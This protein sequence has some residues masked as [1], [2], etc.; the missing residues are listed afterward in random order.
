MDKLVYPGVQVWFSIWKSNNM[1]L[2]INRI[3]RKLTW[4][5]QYTVYRKNIWKSQ[6]SF[7]IKTLSRIEIENNSFNPIIGTCKV[8]TA[9]INFIIKGERQY[10]F[11]LSVGTKLF[12]PFSISI[13]CSFKD[14]SQ[15]NWARK[16]REGI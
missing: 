10:D 3:K 15:G 6:H 5:Y 8:P 9:N 13:Q 1:I 2:H 4:L 12:C 7:M 11:S 14:L 16:E